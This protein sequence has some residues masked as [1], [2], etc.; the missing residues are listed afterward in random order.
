MSTVPTGGTGGRMP[1]WLI[2]VLTGCGGCLLVGVVMMVL[3]GA[4]IK[5]LF[6]PKVPPPAAYVGV[7][8][9]ADSSTLAIGSDGTASFRV[10]NT[11]VTGARVKVDAAGHRLSIK[12]A[13]LG[14]DWRIDSPPNGTSMTLNG[15]QF[16][17]TSSDGSGM[18]AGGGSS[19]SQ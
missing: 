8:H 11:S 18:L 4:T 19:G 2:V 12:L 15:K 10:P 7:W 9:A 14:Q 3:A 13:G 1:A 5:A 6:E 17:R 16:T